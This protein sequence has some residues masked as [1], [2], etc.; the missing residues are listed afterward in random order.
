MLRLERIFK[1]RNVKAQIVMMIHDALWVEA[2]REEAT[3]V[4]HLIQRMMTTAAKTYG[5][6]GSRFQGLNGYYKTQIFSIHLGLQR[7]V[8]LKSIRQKPKSEKFKLPSVDSV[9][10]IFSIPSLGWII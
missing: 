4:R 10:M 1:T 3:E 2:P 6:V 9:K 5:S 8:F 7:F